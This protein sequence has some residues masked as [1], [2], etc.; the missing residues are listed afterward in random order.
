M[1]S[2]THPRDPEL[3]IL[4]DG[5]LT[6]RRQSVVDDHVSECA[7]CRSRLHQIRTTLA[8]ASDLY[9]SAFTP[10]G[11][12]LPASRLRLE[13]A[14]HEAAD[15][16]NQSWLARLNR[17]LALSPTRAALGV[18]AALVLLVAVWLSRPDQIVGGPMDDSAAPLP[19]AALTPGAVSS[20]TEMELCAG[21]RPSRLVTAESRQRV[22]RDY[23]M[24]N[25]SDRVY[26][27][28]ALITPELGGTTEAA[29]L[30]PQRY[31]SPV[32][33]ARVKDELER[34]LPGLVCSNRLDLAQAQREIATDWV[35][36]YKRYFKSDV[37]L[38]AH[39]GAPIADDDDLEFAP[40]RYAAAE[41]PVL[42]LSV[43]FIRP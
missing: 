40:D 12:Q 35:A 25:V 22:L 7:A 37:P 39:V 32:W 41:P 17:A 11:P 16:W 4:L 33:N 18:S 5:E 8:E 21:G 20:L 34:L 1:L 6:G 31:A 27:L 14:L 42:V 15:G 38:Q 10:A 23:R 19:I 2:S 30:W 13:R 26:E 9:E 3:L 29:N 28:D 24:E 43:G 36:A